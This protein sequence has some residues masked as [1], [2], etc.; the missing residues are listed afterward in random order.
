MVSGLLTSRRLLVIIYF[1]IVS[2]QGH[3]LS[4]GCGLWMGLDTAALPLKNPHIN[5]HLLGSRQFW[6]YTELQKQYALFQV[7]MS[8]C[9]QCVPLSFNSPTSN[10]T[11]TE[12]SLQKKSNETT[13][14]TV[15]SLLIVNSLKSHYGS[16][17][18]PRNSIVNSCEVF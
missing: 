10:K 11:S 16:L 18:N 4:E 5:T 14:M 6:E 9:I 12:K 13:K 7:E 3:G 2:L 17:V 1:L 15:C 8:K